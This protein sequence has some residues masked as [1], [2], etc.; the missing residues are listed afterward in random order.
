VLERQRAELPTPR[1][2]REGGEVRSELRDAAAAPVLIDERRV[3]F[4]ES[5]ALALRHSERAHRGVRRDEVALDLLPLEVRHR[6]RGFRRRREERAAP[7]P[8]RE[9]I[10][11]KM[12]GGA[13]QTVSKIRVTCNGT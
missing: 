12:L 8:A 6:R 1:I 10:S 4:I 7:I 3:H 5:A 11:S 13:S 9:V 2:I